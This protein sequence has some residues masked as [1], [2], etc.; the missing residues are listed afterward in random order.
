MDK[1]LEK[2]TS[3]Q[4][5]ITNKILTAKQKTKSFYKVF[6]IV[7]RLMPPAMRQSVVLKSLAN[8][9]KPEQ[10]RKYLGKDI[11]LQHFFEELN[12]KEVRY[13]VLRW[14]EDFPNWPEGE[15]VDLL[16][17]DEDL[18]K[19]KPYF[20]SNAKGQAFDVY[21]ISGLRGSAYG[22]LGPYFP[23]ELGRELLE[24]RIKWD[25]CYIP[26]P[27]HY[28]LSLAYHAVYHK[29]LASGLPAE[30]PPERSQDLP[31]DTDDRREDSPKGY[32]HE[33]RYLD[34]LTEL[35]EE[36]GIDV[37]ITLRDLHEYLTQ[38]G[39]SPSL[40]TLRKLS[41]Q[42]PYVKELLP[43]PKDLRERP[44]DILVFVIRQWA[45]DNG[46][47]D[48]ILQMIEEEGMEIVEYK[49][50]SA[51]E[52]AS[53]A[54]KIRGGQWEGL[55]TSRTSGG[56][57]SFVI[58]AYDPSPKNLSEKQ[59]LKYPFVANANV[60]IKEKIRDT[61]NQDRLINEHVNC[62]HSSDDEL[63]AWEYVR[64]AFPKDHGKLRLKVEEIR[65][66][67]LQHRG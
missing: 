64:V 62:I 13:L 60:F 61:I 5:Y 57:P 28:F 55:E 47:Q 6:P 67:A 10:T 16:I 17:A 52:K 21:S 42:N 46:Y 51:R 30:V 14:F 50:L 54:A 18:G 44:G 34:I 35:G 43:D 12:Q 15:D 26:A 8:K 39:W 7:K 56:G 11:S 2:K 53:V 29:G 31:K 65:R 9:V 3:R 1:N 45:V 40:D 41:L 38:R 24:N 49:E 58:I 4:L 48:R 63:E 36:L 33:Q 23:I 59:R 32:E 19:I 25:Q 20:T 66:Q 22:K 27:F 37:K